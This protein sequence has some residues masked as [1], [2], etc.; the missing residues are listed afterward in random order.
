MEAWSVGAVVGFGGWKLGANYMNEGDSLEK[1]SNTF[2]DDAWAWT[3]GLGYSQ[4]PVHLG[5]S[6]LHSEV[7][8]NEVDDDESDTI[9]LGATYMLGGGAKVYAD[10][11]WLDQDAGD[12]A[13][14][15]ENEGVGFL[16]GV[17][18]K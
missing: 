11:F 17:G 9:V 7:E 8:V 16:V 6:Y 10:L 3:V 5:V 13:S 14:V 1:K 12:P 2:D 15:S 4:G 18:V